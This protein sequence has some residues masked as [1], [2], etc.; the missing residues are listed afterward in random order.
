MMLLWSGNSE[1]VDTPE[2]YGICS[3]YFSYNSEM[4]KDYPI[5]VK[6]QFEPIT[7]HTLF[8]QNVINRLNK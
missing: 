6:G 5:T 8:S 3:L 1:S 7:G 2:S 4:L